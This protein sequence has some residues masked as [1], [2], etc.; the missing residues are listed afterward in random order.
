MR[1]I[2]LRETEPKVVID[3][4]RCSL[5]VNRDYGTFGEFLDVRRRRYDM[6]YRYRG[7]D[8]DDKERKDRKKFGTCP[9]CGHKFADAEKVYFAQSVYKNSKCLGNLL[10]CE[11]CM[12]RVNELEQ[13]Q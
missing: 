10:A 5:I 11:N 4:Y 2:F 8:G 9:G 13:S 7:D 1:E 3:T 6:G 12:K